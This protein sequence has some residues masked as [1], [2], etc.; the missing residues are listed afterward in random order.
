MKTCS[1]CGAEN[2]DDAKFCS[3]CGATFKPTIPIRWKETHLVDAWGF[4]LLMS[5]S[6]TIV[7]GLFGI[8]NL[9]DLILVT[10]GN[11]EFVK[12]ET[13]MG[14]GVSLCCIVI[15]YIS[16][17]DIIRTIQG[18]KNL[19]KMASAVE[20]TKWRFRLITK[21][22]K[23]GLYDWKEKKVLFPVE[24]DLIER[25]S[26]DSYYYT[27]KRNGKYGLY[28]LLIGTIV[29]CEWDAVTPFVNNVATLTKNNTTKQV[30]TAGN[31]F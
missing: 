2:P 3:R 14:I 27:V 25:Q 9:C 5:L 12:F 16:M 13:F 8:L 18:V 20:D 11:G 7:T 28:S 10:T 6:L 17:R 4:V 24:Y 19:K 15:F 23:V 26:P 21:A 29:P 22:G 1:K 31:I 30:D